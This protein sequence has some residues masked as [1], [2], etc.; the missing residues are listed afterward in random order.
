MGLVFLP[1]F[2]CFFVVNVGKY[3][4]HGCYGLEKMGNLWKTSTGW[5]KDQTFIRAVEIPRS[6]I[7]VPNT[8]PWD[9]RYIYLHL[10]DFYGELVG[11]YTSPMDPMGYSSASPSQDFISNCG[12]FRQ[13]F[14]KF[15]TSHATPQP[16]EVLIWQVYNPF[17]PYE[18]LWMGLINLL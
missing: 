2:A 18:S 6:P 17:W 15:P 8:D 1:T 7:R 5:V 16:K 9:E 12:A 11:K 13:S 10:V 3:T 4:I 14:S